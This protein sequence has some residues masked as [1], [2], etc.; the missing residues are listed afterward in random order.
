M[1]AKIKEDLQQQ[2][3]N[4]QEKADLAELLSL[5]QANR[6]QSTN[7]NKEL[8]TGTVNFYYFF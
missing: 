8:L 5:L 3:M 1:S 6:R 4:E 7:L 2:T